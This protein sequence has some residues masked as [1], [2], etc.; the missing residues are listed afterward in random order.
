MSVHENFFFVLLT[1]EII[2]V[3]TRFS[4]HF[5]KVECAKGVLGGLFSFLPCL[6]ARAAIGARDRC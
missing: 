1:C 3:P 6:V 5:S 4:P 2:F